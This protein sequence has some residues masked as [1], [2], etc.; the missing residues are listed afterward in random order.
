MESATATMAM[1]IQENVY[2]PPEQ[3]IEPIDNIACLVRG[4][5]TAMENTLR[6]SEKVASNGVTILLLGESGS[7]KE[8]LA[9]FIH[10]QSPRK[11]KPF[12][13]L[14]CAAIPETLIESELFG[15]EPGAFTG[16]YKLRRG[17]FEAAQGGTI[18]LDEIEAASSALQQKILR[19]IEHKEIERVGGNTT[20]K[21]DLRFIAASNTN[22]KEEVK[23]KRFREDLLFR[24]TVPIHI[25][26]LRNRIDDIPRLAYFILLSKIR[27]IDKEAPTRISVDA[28]CLLQKAMWRGNVRELENVLT[29]AVLSRCSTDKI[30]RAVDLEPFLETIE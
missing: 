19:V 6:L 3:I 23:E 5:N 27:A 10:K 29:Q 8:V 21:V 2:E 28:M 13:A 17:K 14:N 16:A 15:Y 18:F 4:P 7:G 12:C 22:L 20:H 26:P 11:E 9:R 24:L 1:E 25:P 30:L